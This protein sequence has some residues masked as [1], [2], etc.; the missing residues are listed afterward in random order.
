MRRIPFS[1][2]EDRADTLYKVNWLYRP[3]IFPL[4]LLL[5]A[6]TKTNTTAKMS[7]FLCFLSP[8]PPLSASKHMS[9]KQ[10]D[11][12]KKNENTVNILYQD[13]KC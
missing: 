7:I 5:F 11:E 10:Q 8:H 2:N 3:I 4:F 9:E 13:A 6:E 1:K 12:R